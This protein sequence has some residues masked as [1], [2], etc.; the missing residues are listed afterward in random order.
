MER[1]LFSLFVVVSNCCWNEETP[2]YLTVKFLVNYVRLAMI[3]IDQIDHSWRQSTSVHCNFCDWFFVFNVLSFFL[4]FFAIIFFSFVF[5]SFFFFLLFSFDPVFLFS[6]LFCHRFLGPSFFLSLFLSR[7][8]ITSYAI[9]LSICFPAF[10][11][12]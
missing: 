11:L 8:S 10:F 9:H 5:L 12:F 1:H 2:S 4:Y 3:S 6:F 7:P